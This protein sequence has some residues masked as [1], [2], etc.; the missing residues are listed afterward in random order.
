MGKTNFQPLKELTSTLAE[1]LE[2]LSNGQLKRTEIEAIT[3]QAR[4]I[5]ER[6]VIIRFKSY[7]N[8]ANEEVEA[9]PSAKPVQPVPE[10]T[11]HE[12]LMM[13]DF[14][15]SEVAEQSE[16]LESDV[17]ENNSTETSSLEPNITV[18]EEKRNISHE[19][20]DK[21]LNDNFKKDDGSVA[22]KF[23]KAPI[24]DLKE[25]IGINRKFLYVNELFSSDGNAYNA[26]IN[27]LNSCASKTEALT[28]IA[29]LKS[30][31]T[32]KE[33]NP[34][35]IGFIELVERRYLG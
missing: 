17:V 13:F 16:E 12:E 9:I 18:G 19:T 34:T 33:D 32:W 27:D 2:Q 22:G 31:H 6:L 1:K 10:A 7:E 26:A 24:A 35:V 21:S 28:K 15:A 29:A 20:S 11:E 8:S 30:A 25:H 4:E 14:T 3:D 23:E 5:Y